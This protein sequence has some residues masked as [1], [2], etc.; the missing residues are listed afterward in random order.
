MTVP[1]TGANY[2]KDEQV[3]AFY[4]NVLDRVHALP[5][6]EAAGIV[7]V[8]PFSANYDNCGF[9]IEAKPLANP[10][11]APSARRYVITP[12][13][14][15]AMGI[16]L[17]HGRQF[18]EQDDAK[19]PLVA[20]I[21]KTAADR[22]WPGEDPIG[23]RIRLG[24]SDSELRTIVGIVG[25]VRQKGLD[26]RPGIQA[27]EPHAQGNG[28][29]MSLVV[30][31]SVDPAS[32]TAAVRNEI[33]A[34][35]PSLPVYGIMTMRELISSSVAERRFTL[36]LVGVFAAVALFMTAI[37]IYG[38]ISYS[39][40]QRSQEFAIRMALGAQRY[41]VV[42]LVLGQGFRLMLFG[43]VLGV[44]GAFALTRVLEHLLFQT[45]TTDPLT[46]MLVTITLSAAGIIACWLPARRAVRVDPMVALRNE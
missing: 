30:R 42:Q 27:Y 6:V 32:L 45:N 17:L 37:G 10:T 20:L 39:V 29:G 23:K 2:R 19:S 28:N 44:A 40:A 41:E 38:V 24:G 25:D 16:P 43:L 31:T 4:R 34:V 13:Y 36:L 5:G 33:R 12:N 15:R 9:F 22:N 1:A 35:D 3:V 18:N 8:L 14:L 11:Q 26:D 46:F 7:S 21:S